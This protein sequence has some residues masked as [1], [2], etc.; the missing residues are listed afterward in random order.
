MHITDH[1]EAYFA[2]TLLLAALWPLWRTDSF[3][4]QPRHAVNIEWAEA[5][6][7][8][9]NSSPIQL[10]LSPVEQRFASKF[11]GHIARFTDGRYEWIVRVIDQPTRMLHPA[12]DCYRALG[13]SVTPPHVRAEANG[14]QWRC[15]TAARNGKTLKVC[16]RIFD[17]KDGRWTDT[18]AWYWST[19][20][21][22][23]SQARAPWWAVT[24]V[25]RG[26]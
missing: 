20:A 24:K 11:P 7:A 2:V 9:H 17:A 18:S 4:T 10:P 15:F 21:G 23:A 16:E 22:G 5:Q 1:A 26:E 8:P 14:E 13:Y 6:W 25:E 19:L 12:A 3:E